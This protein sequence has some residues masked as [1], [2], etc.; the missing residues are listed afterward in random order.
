MALNA[1]CV[2]FYIKRIKGYEYAVLGI[3]VYGA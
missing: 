1:Y 2:D 3:A